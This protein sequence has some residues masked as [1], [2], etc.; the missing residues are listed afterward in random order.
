[1]K[2]K[3]IV[4]AGVLVLM[5][6]TTAYAGN[7]NDG[8]QTPGLRGSHNGNSHHVNNITEEAWNEYMQEFNNAN[9]GKYQIVKSGNKYKVMNVEG[10]QIEII[11]V[12][13]NKELTE[14]EKAE[15][16]QEPVTPPTEPENPVEPPKEDVTD[17]IV[18]ELPNQEPETGDSSILAYTGIAVASMVSLYVLN[19]RKD[20]D[21]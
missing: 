5:M 1:M 3:S 4:I 14:E 11:H 15:K 17:P 19:K 16:N 6:G 13:F 20:E 9:E 21:K 8:C 10:K 2:M 12:D 18:P 7:G